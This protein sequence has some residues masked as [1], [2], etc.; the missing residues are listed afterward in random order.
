[1]RRFAISF[2]LLLLFTG[3]SRGDDVQTV[4]EPEVAFI[5][6][7]LN[8]TVTIETERPIEVERPDPEDLQPFKVIDGTVNTVETESGYRTDILYTLAAFETGMLELP[9]LRLRYKT[10]GEKIE[11]AETVPQ[12][13]E[14]RS[15][16]SGEEQDIADIKPPEKEK[17]AFNWILLIIIVLTGLVLLGLLF[18][19]LRRK[20][21]LDLSDEEPLS[22]REEALAMIAELKREDYIGKGRIKDYYLV[23]SHIIRKYLGRRFRVN[24][25]E[26]TCSEITERL[27]RLSLKLD[28]IRAVEEVVTAC[29]MVVFARYRPEGN[30]HEDILEEIIRIIDITGPA[31][32]EEES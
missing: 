4:L 28:L 23:L 27:C 1:M 31:P 13:I 5:G 6:D 12:T 11:I 7:R 9:V 24:A 16:L 10:A 18:M 17:G 2:C 15:V 25:L 22:P 26:S 20:R 32:E 29:D 21:S 14:I 8:L 19:F 30:R 3:A